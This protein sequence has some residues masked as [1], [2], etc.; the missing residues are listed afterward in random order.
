[1]GRDSARKRNTTVV[2]IRRDSLDRQRTVSE[3]Y[4]DLR[5]RLN[6]GE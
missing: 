3:A 5:K 4:M 2:T 6:S 1:M